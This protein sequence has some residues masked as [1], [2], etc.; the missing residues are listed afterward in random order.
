MEAKALLLSKQLCA[1]VIKA[2]K[3]IMEQRSEQAQVLTPAECLLKTA[4]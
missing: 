1:L 3:H 4:L 2:E